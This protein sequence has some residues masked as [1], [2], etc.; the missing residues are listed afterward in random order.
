METSMWRFAAAL[1]AV[2]LSLACDSGEVYSAA[3]IEAAVETH[4][5]GRTDLRFDGLEIRA[6]RIRYGGDRAVAE[7]SIMASGDP[8]A[9][10]QMVYELERGPDGWR[11]VP[12]DPARSDSP[13][14]PPGHGLPPNLPPGHPPTDQFGTELPPGHPPLDGDPPR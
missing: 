10:M 6:D 9:V 11:V 14:A 12:P 7:V 3:E 4:L 8:D 2:G 13:T 5:A 1:A